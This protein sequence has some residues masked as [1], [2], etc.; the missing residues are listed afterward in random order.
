MT[1]YKA[2]LQVQPDATPKFHKAHSIPIAIKDAVGAELN[3]LEGEGILQ[4]VSHSDWAVPIVQMYI[5]PKL[6][7]KIYS[8]RLASIVHPLNQLLQRHKVA[9]DSK[10]C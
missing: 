4:R 9:I 8:Y 1:T 6:L 3:R 10:L 7:W 2:A 5:L